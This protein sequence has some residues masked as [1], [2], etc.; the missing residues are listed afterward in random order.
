MFVFHSTVFVAI[1]VISESF[2]VSPF[3]T[4]ELFWI[5]Y[6]HFQKIM[7]R[8]DMGRDMFLP[9]IGYLLLMLIKSIW[10]L[11]IFSRVC[12][13]A[14]QYE[15]FLDVTW[16]MYLWQ[17][18]PFFWQTGSTFSFVQF[19]YQDRS[20]PQRFWT[21]PCPILSLKSPIRIFCA[22]FFGSFR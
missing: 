2:A 21:E 13:G 11:M 6:L 4:N 7:I 16:R 8:E 12:P 14:Y 10:F 9:V 18:C 3:F 19:S 20:F 5:E 15:T 22:Y 1:S 17:P